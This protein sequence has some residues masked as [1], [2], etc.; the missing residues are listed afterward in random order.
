METESPIKRNTL[1][2]LLILMIL[3]WGLNWPLMKLAIVDISVWF[4]VF[5]RMGIGIVVV[6]IYLIVTKQWQWPTLRA[7]PLIIAVGVLQMTV[8]NVLM[9]GALRYIDASRGVILSYSTPLWVAPAAILIFKEKF[10]RTKITG[11]MLGFIGILLLFNPWTFNWHDRSS[12]I[13]SLLLLL[14]SAVWAGSILL[15]RQYRTSFPTICLTFWQLFLPLTILFFPNFVWGHPAATQW[16]WK[17]V[18]LILYGGVIATAFCFVIVILIS[19]Y[20]PSTTT[21]LTLLGVP[22]AG[23]ALSALILGEHIGVNKII[24]MLSVIVGVALVLWADKRLADEE[25]PQEIAR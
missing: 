18:G 15:I 7:M 9:V 17:L 23:M 21:S 20:L 6:G 25:A 24:A 5:L 16:S 12:L 11:I 10:N 4:Y 2:I 3:F 8:C 19:R 13:A 22:V 1:I 14:A